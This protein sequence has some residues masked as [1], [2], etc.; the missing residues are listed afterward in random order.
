MTGWFHGH[1]SISNSVGRVV[2][3][4]PADARS[5]EVMA[6][7]AGLAPRTETTRKTTRTDTTH[8]P[9]RANDTGL[10]V[11]RRG[12]PVQVAG[13]EDLDLLTM[14]AGR[15]DPGLP[16]QIAGRGH[17]LTP[18]AGQGNLPAP[19]NRLNPTDRSCLPRPTP[20]IVPPDLNRSRTPISRLLPIRLPPRALRT[21]WQPIRPK[22]PRPLIARRTR[23]SE[24]QTKK[25]TPYPK[26]PRRPSEVP[27]PPS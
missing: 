17:L 8:L 1:R 4:G 26:D 6:S 14:V 9:P 27:S 19:A 24:S 15:E 7:T 11:V 2:T 22:A 23:G 13:R 16:T 18:V 10:I 5:R 21:Q 12:P 3:G 25:T 20:K